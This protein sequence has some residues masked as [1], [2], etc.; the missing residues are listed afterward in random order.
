MA[1]PM[2]VAS[3]EVI[4]ERV[5][6]VDLPVAG[7]RQTF[8][9]LQATRRKRHAASRG[10]ALLLLLSVLTVVATTLAC[11]RGGGRTLTW[12]PGLERRSLSEENEEEGDLTLSWLVAECLELQ[13]EIGYAVPHSPLREK[14]EAISQ[15]VASMQQLQRSLMPDVM[16]EEASFSALSHLS[17]TSN[18]SDQQFLAHTLEELITSATEL[19]QHD[20]AAA[21]SRASLSTPAGLTLPA[22]PSLPAQAVTAV[23]SQHESMSISD[24][25]ARSSTAGGRV[26]KRGRSSGAAPE[27]SLKRPRAG[28]TRTQRGSRSFELS[29]RKPKRTPRKKKAETPR[30][31]EGDQSTSTDAP[32]IQLVGESQSLSA[33]GKSATPS[34]PLSPES[35]LEF[36]KADPESLPSSPESREPLRIFVPSAAASTHST[37]QKASDITEAAPQ[38]LPSSS[39]PS[40]DVQRP[41]VL[42]ILDA[43]SSASV[44]S[45]NGLGAAA[46]RTVTIS[47]KPFAQSPG[48]SQSN[49]SRAR[50]A[51]SPPQSPRRFEELLKADLESL[52][53]SPEPSSDKPEPP[54]PPV[55]LL[56]SPSRMPPSA[57]PYFRLPDVEPGVRPRPFN[58]G[59]IFVPYNYRR[60]VF[61]T[62][63]NVRDLLLQRRVSQTQVDQLVT[64][65]E[66]LANYLVTS[67]T[68]ELTPLSLFR[69]V[70]SLAYRYLCFDALVSTMQVIGLEPRALPWWTRLTS[71]IPTN[72]EVPWPRSS[73]RAF[74]FRR[75]T[76]RLSS[77]LALLKQGIRPSA[78][79][80]VTLK[81]DLFRGQ[82]TTASFRRARWNSWRAL[83]PSECDSSSS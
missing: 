36:L 44:L 76:R 29:G 77:A 82:T 70:N 5:T 8:K 19:P 73:E 72:Y 61:K 23:F 14:S 28:A 79:E 56:S 71:I 74:F 75:L 26:E 13:E 18:P 6:L 78:L 24:E 17:Y 33:E 40:A 52:P 45:G 9:L 35:F 51:P 1:A 47:L 20:S 32:A 67:E 43:A 25:Q 3:P 68:D 57:H 39:A 21:D 80:T 30:H 62:L 38:S 69:V 50:G 15:M 55:P 37:P 59:F 10:A 34:S 31:A 42:L 58:E 48:P 4:G 22:Q 64:E 66:E 83:D 60:A 63:E 49:V 7:T 11:Y 54:P 46:S 27:H 2:P 65:C 41:P 12:K 81:R 16:Q 53:S